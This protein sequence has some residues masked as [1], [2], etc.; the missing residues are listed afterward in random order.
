LL[1]ESRG[2]D[3]IGQRF[4]IDRYGEQRLQHNVRN[5]CA[6]GCAECEVRLAAAKNDR[7]RERCA[8]AGEIAQLA[9]VVYSDLVGYV[10]LV[11]ISAG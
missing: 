8:L 1:I 9:R 5:R 4:A 3:G 11:P 2:A 10:R 7:G 6:A